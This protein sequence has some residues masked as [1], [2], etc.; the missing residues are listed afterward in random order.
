VYAT[1]FDF[2][3]M[4]EELGEHLVRATGETARPFEELGVG[5]LREQR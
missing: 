2:A 3:E 5:E 1:R 4:N